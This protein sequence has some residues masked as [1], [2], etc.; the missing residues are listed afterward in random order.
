M[1]DEKKIQLD[2]ACQRAKEA[3][4]NERKIAEVSD[5]WRRMALTSSQKRDYAK[6]YF[7]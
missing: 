2:I 1:M 4:R 7:R 5:A 6:K 3:I